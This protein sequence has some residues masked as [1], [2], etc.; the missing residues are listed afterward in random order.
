M[1]DATPPTP[2]PAGPPKTN[3]LAIISLVAALIGVLTTWLVPI[4]TQLVAIVCGHIARAQIR[5]SDGTQEGAGI[6]LAGLIIG[7]VML[8][9]GFVFSLLFGAAM[10]AVM[11]AF[12]GL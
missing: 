4:V 2:A 6:A 12:L 9:V 1:T 7:Y 3:V 10:L 5:R 8:L 11:F